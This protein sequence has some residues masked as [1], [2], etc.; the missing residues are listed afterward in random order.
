MTLLNASMLLGRIYDPL[1]QQHC[2][3]AALRAVGHQ[4][5][6]FALELDGLGAADLRQPERFLLDGQPFIVECATRQGCQVVRAL[7]G[8]VAGEKE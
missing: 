8:V 4:Q 3:V 5:E 2:A 1:A 7:D 6:L